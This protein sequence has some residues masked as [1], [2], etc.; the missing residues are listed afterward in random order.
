[1]NPSLEVQVH[2][3][4]GVRGRQR[5]RTGKK[6]PAKPVE[7]GRIPRISKL[8]ALAIHFD[9]LIRK[10]VVRDYADIARLGQVSRARVSQIMDLLN[11]APDIQE[12]IL[13]L[14]RVREGRDP[15]TERQ[16]RLVVK[17]DNW[18]TQ[19]LGWIG[20]C[21]SGSCGV[22]CPPDQCGPSRRVHDCE[23]PCRWG[24]T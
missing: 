23:A 3:R 15:V 18:A 5:L 10:G 20:T 17:D 11:L 9:E 19:R 2:F 16:I 1:M 22:A 6:A 14:P 8:M 24:T 13:F 12:E 7:P 21:A 4:R